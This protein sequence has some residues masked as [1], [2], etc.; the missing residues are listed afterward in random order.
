MLEVSIHKKS[1]GNKVILEEAELHI[2]E[3]G[4]YGV[5]GKNGAG[6]TSLFSCMLSLTDFKGQVL[7]NGTP[8]QAEQVGFIPTEPYLYDYLTVGEFYRFYAALKQLKLTGTPIYLR[9]TKSCS[10]KNSPQGCVAKYTSMLCYKRKA[11]ST[12]LMSLSMGL[13]IETVYTLRRLIK[14]LAEEHIVL[15]ASHLLESLQSCK[16]IFVVKDRKVTAVAPP[17]YNTIETILFQD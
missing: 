2:A 3:Q 16:T 17:D 14:N 7:Y 11:T 10:S 8:L 6:K 5:V 12:S 1:Y 9:L 13:D 15:I 4:L